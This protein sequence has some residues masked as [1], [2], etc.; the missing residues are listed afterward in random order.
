M[1]AAASK[2]KAKLTADHAFAALFGLVLLAAGFHL[3]AFVVT[4]LL[5]LEQSAGRR[6]NPGAAAVRFAMANA[7]LA[8]SAPSGSA[9]SVATTCAACA[10]WR[11]C[12]WEGSRCVPGVPTEGNCNGDPSVLAHRLAR[13]ATDAGVPAQHIDALR[14]GA[15]ARP[16]AIEVGATNSRCAHR[17]PY[18]VIMTAASGTYQ[19]W[20]SRIAYYHYLK[21]KVRMSIHPDPLCRWPRS[22]FFAGYIYLSI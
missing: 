8:R 13:A 19:E 11:S 9:C 18:H 12:A 1:A 15:A 22:Y 20:Q 14:G 7:S 10:V 6:V 21:L 3:H 17:N 2:P 4:L 5:P 16:P